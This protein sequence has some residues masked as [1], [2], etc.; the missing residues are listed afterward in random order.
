M[1]L[2]YRSAVKTALETPQTMT[3]LL[4]VILRNEFG[5]EALD[6]DPITLYMELRE[7]FKAEPVPE[8]MD[9]LSAIQV[10]VLTD[11]FF[12]RADAFIN[13][14]NTI[15][16]GQPSFSMFDTATTEEC[17]WSLVEVSLI[18]DLRRFDYGVT[19]YVKHTLLQDGYDEGNYPGLFVE[20]FDKDPSASELVDEVQEVVKG[21]NH[22]VLDEFLEEQ[23][24]SLVHQFNEIPGLAD[25]LMRLLD[26]KDAEEQ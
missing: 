12:T 19:R 14:C 10:L 17:A 6:W 15:A 9:R 3:T 13:I 2:D 22:D 25:D 20:A 23:M 8:V 11:V 18:R 21:P 7:T 4:Y 1:G 24:N 5:D 16:D 26:E